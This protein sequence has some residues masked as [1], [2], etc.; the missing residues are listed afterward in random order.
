MFLTDEWKSGKPTERQCYKL[1]IRQ[2]TRFDKNTKFS[3]SSSQFYSILNPISRM[4]QLYGNF[5]LKNKR[6]GTS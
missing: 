6:L 4:D 1:I 3:A 2:N 5:I